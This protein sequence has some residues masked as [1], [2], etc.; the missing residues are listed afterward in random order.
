[1]T[2]LCPHCQS[3][4]PFVPELTGGQ[5]F[6]SRRVPIKGA[7][8]DVA[9]AVSNSET[10]LYVYYELRGVKFTITVCT[11]CREQLVVENYSI[12]NSAPRVVAP[13]PE[14]MI[15]SEI[16]ENVRKV[17]KEAMQ[18][19]HIGADTASLLAARTALIRTLRDQGC[20][21][22]DDLAKQRKITP[23]LAEQANEA[24]RWANLMGHDDVPADFPAGEDANQLLLYLE[25]LFDVIYVQP[26]KLKV[27]KVKR[28]NT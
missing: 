6:T 28:E 27:L 23:L 3:K 19:H 9:V 10:N 2:V 15:P 21:R 8:D 17:F 14:P 24:R 11:E 22:I 1:M 12:R 18:A 13:L 20:S 5:A 4:I 25:F 26:A 7:L 16:P